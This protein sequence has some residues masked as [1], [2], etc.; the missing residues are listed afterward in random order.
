MRDQSRSFSCYGTRNVSN[1]QPQ[2]SFDI[3]VRCYLH[4]C[5]CSVRSP[6][7]RLH[8]CVLLTHNTLYTLPT[9]EDSDD[10]F[11]F[12]HLHFLFSASVKIGP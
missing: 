5:V 2:H 11:Y 6:S 9:R 10:Q 12:H 3:E 8:V 1:L 7:T 4:R